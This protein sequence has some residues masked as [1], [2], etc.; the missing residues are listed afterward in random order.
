MWDMGS[1]HPS[2]PVESLPI[3]WA[4]GLNLEGGCR[5]AGGR[6]QRDLGPARPYGPNQKATLSGLENGESEL[7]P[8]SW[9]F[10]P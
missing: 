1:D 9:K 5:A 3:D 8:L 4:T 2:C 6:V 7:C 10:T